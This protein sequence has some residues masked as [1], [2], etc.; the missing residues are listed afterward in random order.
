MLRRVI[1]PGMA[2]LAVLGICASGIP[3]AA[4]QTLTLTLDPTEAAK[5]DM[6]L[7]HETTGATKENSTQAAT[8]T[9]RAETQT[10]SSDKETPIGRVGV[11]IATKSDIKSAPSSKSRTYYTC[12]K[13]TYLAI[14]GDNRDWYG[15]LMSDGSTGWIPKK[16]VSLLD[17]Q[18]VGKQPQSSASSS[19]IVN[20]ALKYLGIPYVWGGYSF[21]GL[22]CSGFVKAVFA[23]HG[24]NLP[25]VSRDQANVGT[26]V[27][28]NQLQPGDRLYFACKGSVIDHTGIY[29]GNGMFIHASSSRGGVGIDNLVNSRYAAWL[30]SAR[31][32]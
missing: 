3:A 11:I 2:L 21:S 30:V 25:R 15:V 10:K 26:P 12:P 8:K 32:S 27:P 4:E 24:I 31:R 28:F 19:A 6:R 29:I 18:V 16:C 9:Y 20:T 5:D 22:D 7:K 14:T 17:Y 1:W 13:D 23:S